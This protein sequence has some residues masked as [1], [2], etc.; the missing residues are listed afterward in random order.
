MATNDAATRN[1]QNKLWY[2]QLVDESARMTTICAFCCSP[3]ITATPF[4][5]LRS[6]P[7]T[8]TTPTSIPTAFISLLQISIVFHHCTSTQ[9]IS[10]WLHRSK[11]GI[12]DDQRSLGRPHGT[13]HLHSNT[14]YTH[15]HCHLHKSLLLQLELS[16]AHHRNWFHVRMGLST[17]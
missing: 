2:Y 10:S 3:I 6:T 14:P 8:T 13:A 9:I 5:P 15:I 1:D 17:Q 11:D 12:P 7:T 4:D 16:S